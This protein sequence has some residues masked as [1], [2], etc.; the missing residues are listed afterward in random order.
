MQRLL[1]FAL[2]VVGFS[3]ALPGPPLVTPEIS[4]AAG[5]NALALISGA[6]LIARSRRRS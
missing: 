5:V 3:V 1:A 6:V 2:L 4:P